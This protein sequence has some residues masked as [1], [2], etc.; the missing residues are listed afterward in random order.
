M[1][2]RMYYTR[3]WVI[4][5]LRKSQRVNAEEFIASP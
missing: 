3:I 1:D 5:A 2:K 4:F